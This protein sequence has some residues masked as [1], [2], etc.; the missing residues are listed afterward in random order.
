MQKHMFDGK[1]MIE[2]VKILLLRLSSTRW[3]LKK[4][5]KRKEKGENRIK[6]TMELKHYSLLDPELSYRSSAGSGQWACKLLPLLRHTYS[7]KVLRRSST[8]ADSSILVIPSLS[9]SSF[10]ASLRSIE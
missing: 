8:R 10:T 1:V 4:R 6:V 7:S 3:L 2:K 5:E 9:T